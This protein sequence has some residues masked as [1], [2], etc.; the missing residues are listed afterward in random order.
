MYTGFGKMMSEMVALYSKND[1]EVS[2]DEED[3]GS[4]IQMSYK[5]SH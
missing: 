1:N 5:N 3:D 2:N 4:Q